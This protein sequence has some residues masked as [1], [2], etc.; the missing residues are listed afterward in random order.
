MLI[1]KKRSGEIKCRAVFNRK[2]TRDWLSREDTTSP[3]AMTK[4]LFITGVIDAKEERDEMS[5]DVPNAFIQAK[6]P[7]EKRADEKV[8]MKITGRLVDYLVE[9]APKTYAKYVVYENGRKVLY[10]EVLRALY[11]MLI[12]AMLW[13]NK[14]RSDLE[15]IGFEFNPYDPCVANRIVKK[16][17]HTVR[18]HVDDLLSSH[19]DS[20]VNDKFLKWLEH[21]YGEHGKVKVTR[22]KVHEFLGMSFDFRTKGKL[23]VDMSKYMKKMY[24]D[25][26]QKYVLKNA[27]VLPAANDLFAN[28]EKS[29]KLDDEMREDF[30]TYTAGGLFACKRARPDTATAISVL[31]TRVRS[32]SVDDWQKLLCYMQYVK[33]TWKDVLT[34]S[35]DSL[36]VV[37]WYA[38]ASFAVHPD[39]WSHTGSVMTMGEGAMQSSS[40][41][42]KLNTQSSTGSEL[43]GCDDS[44]TKILWTRWFIEAQGYRIRE[45][46][47]YQDNKSTILLITNGRKSAGK[48]SRAINIRYFFVADQQQKGFISAQYCPTKKMWADPLTKP[49]QGSE[50]KLG[51]DRLMGRTTD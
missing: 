28:D 50:F 7:P 41:K 44:I 13:Y 10:V 39:F 4:G 20:R 42:Q 30:H 43:V 37:K 27:A 17:Q 3:T 8:I 15:E 45:N 24:E 49:L 38:D 18:F 47:L 2:N 1:T 46:I 5:T 35:A 23:K 26:E 31:S 12:S 11:G 33:R 22:G 51:A 34:L 25:F 14:F 32:P 9:I 21:N 19:V 48:R 16:K 29:P 40:S 6:I 36:N